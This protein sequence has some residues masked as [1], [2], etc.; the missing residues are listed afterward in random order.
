MKKRKRKPT[1]VV[2][3][4]I[5]RPAHEIAI[6]ALKKI[7]E[8]KLWQQG[9]YKE[10]HSGVADTIRSYIEHRF[11][12]TAMEMPSDDTLSHFRNNLVSPEAFEKL[13]YLLQSADMVKFAKGIPVGSENEL[14]MQNAFDFIALTKQASKEDFEKPV[15]E[16]IKEVAP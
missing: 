8:Q 14:S 9:F 13:R 10:Y 11:S 1:E 16:E 5:V 15:T 12:I 2:K 7:Q 6:E 3:K 4:V